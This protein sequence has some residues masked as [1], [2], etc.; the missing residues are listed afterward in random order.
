MSMGT[1]SL[2]GSKQSMANFIGPTMNV[3]DGFAI[4]SAGS[5][6]LT[7]GGTNENITL[8]PSG[9]G[10]AR[11]QRVG[12]NSQFYVQSVTSGY[13][14][15]SMEGYS[16]DTNL[17]TTF[18]GGANVILNNLSTAA[19]TYSH[20]TG[21]DAGGNAVGRIA[22]VNVS[23]ATNEGEF[24]FLTRPSGGAL[25]E[26]WRVKSDGTLQASASSSTLALKQGANGK[27]GTF[28]L[29]AGAATVA[30]TSVT[31]N[32]VVLMTLK[33]VGGT[34]GTQAPMIDT[35]TPSTGFTVIAAAGNTSV[36]NYVILEATP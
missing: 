2:L 28:T 4:V 35:I 15:V 34:I 24:A 9:T 20:I 8:T 33:T 22:F 12:A 14:I 13:S 3:P 27:A 36:Y 1:A 16:S 30:N 5:I 21:V 6:D 32:S 26:R 11:V 29:T 31:A 23:D 19:N 10:L 7:A 25:T 17:A 18:G